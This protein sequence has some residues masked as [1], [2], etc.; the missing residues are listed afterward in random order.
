MLFC[1]INLNFDTL[2]LVNAEQPIVINWNWAPDTYFQNITIKICMNMY[3]T[4]HLDDT[5]IYSS[6]Y[7]SIFFHQRFY[8]EPHPIVFHHQIKNNGPNKSS[9]LRNLASCR[10]G[11]G[12]KFRWVKVSNAWF[13]LGLTMITVCKQREEC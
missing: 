6:N 11:Y 5:V 8:S 9:K 2:K 1:I 4:S 12:L 10:K 13:S 7:F 3:Q